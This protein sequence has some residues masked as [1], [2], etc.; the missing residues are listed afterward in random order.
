MSEKVIT[1]LFVA[2]FDSNVGYAWRLI[3]SFWIA[4]NQHM[5]SKNGKCILFYP[6]I[7]KIPAHI[8]ETNI[9]TTQQAFSNSPASLMGDI[10]NILKYKI[11]IIYLTDRKT[12]S[13]KYLLYRIFG[14]SLIIVHDHKPGIR[15]PL[16]GLKK[17]IKKIFR[18]IPG[19]S[20]D[21]AFAVSPYI[22][23]RLREID[24][25]P[26]HKVYEITNGI[27]LEEKTFVPKI[28]SGDIK[29]VTVSRMT[30]YKGIEFGLKVIKGALAANPNIVI[31]Y[32]V[33]GDGPDLEHFK[34]V[35]IEL[36]IQNHV[37][38]LGKRSDVK[39]ILSGCDIAMHPSYGEAL[40]LA[41]LEYMESR[42]PLLCS[43]NESV[44]S[45]LQNNEDSL[46]YNEHHLQDA[47]EKLS[48]LIQSEDLR[49][50]LAEKAYKKL[51][52]QH[53]IN[54]THQKLIAAWDKSLNK[55]RI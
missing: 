22:A 19:V 42:T 45:I 37:Q 29:V 16:S 18:T 28:S 10:K 38:F 1:T 30:T 31:E 21:A 50:N 48:T 32:I 27:T 15:P 55:L 5:N 44:S 12:A 54:L 39:E 41:I 4:I 49:N 35:A 34:K 25:M 52:E 40:S 47:I 53:D 3:E 7:S 13:L 51:V 23:K 6:T 33:I 17:L 36:N 20:C 46:L 14:V 9:E 11:D 2:N 43:D 8:E 24:L 26:P